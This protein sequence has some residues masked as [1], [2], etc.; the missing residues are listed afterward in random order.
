M[1]SGSRPA[2]PASRVQICSQ[3]PFKRVILKKVPLFLCLLFLVSGALGQYD[4]PLY[5]AYTT[6]AEKIKLHER[7]IHSIRS[8]LSVALSDSTEENWEDAFDAVE[9]LLYHSVFTD[10]RIAG[11]FDSLEG[12]SADFQQALLTLVYAQYPHAFPI[13]VTHLLYNTTDTVLAALCG[14]YLLKQHNP[15]MTRNLA[16][17]LDRKFGAAKGGSPVL[18]V[19]RERIR[20][21]LQGYTPPARSTLEALF[22][23]DF[24]KGHIVMYSIQRRDRDYPGLVLIR[25]RNGNFVTDSNGTIFSVP[26]LARSIT[27]LPY[28]L[29]YGN[30]PQGVFLMH[31]F[32]VSMANFIGPTANILLEMPVEADARL[33]LNDETA[34][35]TWRLEDYK[36]LLPASLQAFEPLC[37]VYDAGNCGRRE[38]IAH[39]T[40]IDPA[41]YLHQPYYPLTPSEG[42][43]CT[44][45]IWNGKRLQS[46]QLRLVNALLKAGGAEGYCVV[47]DLDDQKR[48][49]AL[50]E[51]LPFLRQGGRNKF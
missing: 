4:P 38:I 44:K 13:Q 39:G 43:L 33:F 46:D 29:H 48:P 10:Q 15:D 7:L 41:Y 16:E 23:R 12:R 24:L 9:V 34:D 18:Q 32:Q 8:N 20:Q 40:T 17:S 36:R 19:L 31:G 47:I 30:T 6:A 14:E 37:E 22:N 51:V 28:Y 27:G 49:V 45:E 35:T 42:C 5:V 2:G 21:S 3:D 26:Q 50:D 11:A 1:F 25:D